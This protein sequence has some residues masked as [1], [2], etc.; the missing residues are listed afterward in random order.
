MD[1]INRVHRLAVRGAQFFIFNQ[2][3]FALVIIYGPTIFPLVVGPSITHPDAIYWP[4][5]ILL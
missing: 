2:S 5:G 1:Y 4:R 3:L